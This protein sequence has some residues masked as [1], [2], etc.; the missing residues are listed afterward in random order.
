MKKT[1]SLASLGLL[2]AASNSAFAHV[3]YGDLNLFPSQTTTFTR[4]GW[5]RGTDNPVSGCGIDGTPECLGD[6]HLM[7][8]FKFTLSQ[9]SDVTISFTSGQNGLNPA[10]SLYSG[11]LPDEAHDDTTFDPLNALDS[12]FDPIPHPTDS[13]YW[14]SSNIREGQFNALGSWS[15]ANDSDEW[16]EI[17]YITHMNSNSLSSVGASE[18]LNYVLQAGSYTIAAAGAS[19]SSVNA[20]LS[21]TLSFSAVPV[22]VP[23]PSAVW[24]M[25]SAVAG[26]GAMGGRRKSN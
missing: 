3:D 20:L 15:M 21:G 23:L 24:L 18:V 13:A 8:F 6:S 14:N 10:F 2:L 5:F 26:F 19:S 1:T 4:I 11:L 9:D 7:Q 22:A 16:A 25:G 17:Q 12:N